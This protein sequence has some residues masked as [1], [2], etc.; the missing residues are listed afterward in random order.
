MK[1]Y[2]DQLS[3]V[4]SDE[5]ITVWT[6]LEK[7]CENL[8]EVLTRRAN[9]VE[10]VDTLSARNAELKTTLNRY[11]GDKSNQYFQVPPGQTIRVR[12]NYGKGSA[13]LGQKSKPKPAGPVKLM[14][15]TK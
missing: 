4:V 9:L 13:K 8:K 1:L 5:S 6:Q 11:L 2:W 3:Q 15:Q 10:T 14:S 7:D 12:S